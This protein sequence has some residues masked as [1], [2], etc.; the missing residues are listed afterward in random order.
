MS[1]AKMFLGGLL[2]CLS[3]PAVAQIQVTPEVGVSFY[4][5]GK[6]NEKATASPRLGIGVDYYFN[7]HKNGWGLKSG[8]FFYQKKD[9]YTLVRSICQDQSGKL[10]DYMLDGAKPPVEMVLKKVITD[11]TYIR[12]DYLQLPVMVSYKWKITDVYAVSASVGGYIAVGISG[13]HQIDEYTFLVEDKTQ[14]YQRIAYDSPYDLLAYNRF[15]TG[16]SSRLS[17]HAKDLSIHLN[18]ETNLYRR[19]LMGHENLI[20]ITAGFTF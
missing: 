8:L 10:F 2:V 18:Y 3:M 9:D 4:K 5:E 19:K 11:D 16:F 1:I 13:K 20:S 7:Q 15:D 14:E 6:S 17:V 12:R